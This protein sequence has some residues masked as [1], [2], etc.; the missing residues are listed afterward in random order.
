MAVPIVRTQISHIKTFNEWCLWTWLA[1]SLVLNWIHWKLTNGA[2]EM[3]VAVVG[4]GVRVW[5]SGDYDRRLRR[6]ARMWR[7]YSWLVWCAIRNLS[8]VVLNCETIL[9]RRWVS[10]EIE[11]SCF[12]LRNFTWPAL[13]L[14]WNWALL[15][16]SQK[17]VIKA[18]IM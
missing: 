9:D 3:V 4:D 8:L 13:C 12:K 18:S 17:M 10:A 16:V 15:C 14:R 11:C 7:N 6:V 5:F 1:W 2:C